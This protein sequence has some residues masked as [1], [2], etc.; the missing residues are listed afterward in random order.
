MYVHHASFSFASASSFNTS[1]TLI[2]HHQEE[3]SD[4]PRFC[5][6]YISFGLELIA[7]ILSAVADVSPEMKERVKKVLQFCLSLSRCCKIHISA[8]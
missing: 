6:F 1:L 7:L 8:T 4:V 2:F 3:I 5:L